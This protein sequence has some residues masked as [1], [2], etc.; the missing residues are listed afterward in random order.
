MEKLKFLKKK[1]V[2]IPALS[3]AS[4]ISWM[5]VIGGIAGYFLTKHLAGQQV[6]ASGRIKSF[7][8]KIGNYRFHFHHW[9]IG[10]SLLILSFFD[11]LPILQGAFSQGLIIGM[12][13]QGIFDY[14]DWYQLIKK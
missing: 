13:A 14:S 7:I 6:G 8:L 3:L 10:L 12:M 5:T 1:K 2:L 11:I 9:L 4:F